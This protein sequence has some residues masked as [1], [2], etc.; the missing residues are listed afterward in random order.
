MYVEE[1]GVSSVARKRIPLHEDRNRMLQ[2]P[3]V[4]RLRP[5][6]AVA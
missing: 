2:V 5:A 4:R 3:G 6:A 1:R